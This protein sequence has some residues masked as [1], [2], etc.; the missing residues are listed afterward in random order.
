MK[1][2][3][4]T[5]TGMLSDDYKERF[6]AEYEQTKI[7]YEKLKDFCNKIEVAEITGT[8]VPKHDCPFSLLREQKEYMRIY[9]SVLE[10]RAL[11]EGIDIQE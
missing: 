4:D 6:I 7:R 11:I 3:K 10:K 5:I 2:L 8:E 1:D 9:L